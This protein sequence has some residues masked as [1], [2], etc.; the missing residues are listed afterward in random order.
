MGRGGGRGR[1]SRQVSSHV[2]SFALPSGFSYNEYRLLKLER[3]FFPQTFCDLLSEDFTARWAT[4]GWVGRFQCLQESF[5]W[6]W[7][8]LEH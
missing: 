1:G 2:C 8:T 7:L 6:R 4:G 5:V 3:F